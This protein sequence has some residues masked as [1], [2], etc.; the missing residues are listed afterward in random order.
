MRAEPLARNRCV[1]S[2]SGGGQPMRGG[3]SPTC[4]CRYLEKGSDF[5]SRAQAKRIA[6]DQDQQGPL[7]TLQ[8]LDYCVREFCRENQGMDVTKVLEAAERIVLELEEVGPETQ[9]QQCVELR[10][11]PRGATSVRTGEEESRF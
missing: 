6:Q 8:E 9:G 10:N 3:G 1:S 5:L 11:H 7:A 4:A 2:E